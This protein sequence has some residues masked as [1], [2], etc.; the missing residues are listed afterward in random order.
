MHILNPRTDCPLTVHQSSLGRE[1]QVS[2]WCSLVS[3]LLYIY[4]HSSWFQ[5]FLLFI[6][7]QTKLLI[8]WNHKRHSVFPLSVSLPVSYLLSLLQR[9]C[10][11]RNLPFHFLYEDKFDLSGYCSRV[12]L[13]VQASRVQ[14]F[15]V[16]PIPWLDLSSRSAHE[17]GG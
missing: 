9:T 17:L 11:T 7:Q 12:L 13:R 15:Q 6:E 10:Y 14:D 1:S 16:V 8:L 5:K 2:F 3:V 4:W